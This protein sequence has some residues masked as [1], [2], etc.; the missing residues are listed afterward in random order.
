MC[1]ICIKIFNKSEN[2]GIARKSRGAGK[3]FSTGGGW[4]LR[5]AGIILLYRGAEPLGGLENLG[6]ETLLDSTPFQ[7]LIFPSLNQNI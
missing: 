3:F 4:V 5:G 6:G 7:F 1:Q 2:R